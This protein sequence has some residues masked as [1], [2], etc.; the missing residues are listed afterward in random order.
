MTRRK[1]LDPPECLEAA[2]PVEALGVGIECIEIQAR[3]IPVARERFGRVDQTP[4]EAVIAPWFGDPQIADIEPAP[5]GRPVDAADE[6]A[7]RIMREDR[8][9]LFVA[10]AEALRDMIGKA[11]GHKGGVPGGRH[12][13]RRD[14]EGMRP[15]RFVHWLF[16][17]IVSACVV[18]SASGDPAMAETRS[19]PAATKA[20]SPPLAHVDEYRSVF[21]SCRDA[22]GAARLATRSMTV[23]GAPSL[24]LVDA[25]SLATSIEPAAAWTCEDTSDAVQAQTRFGRAL[26]MPI[27]PSRA[28]SGVLRDSGLVHGASDGSFVTGDLCPTAKPLARGFLQTLART[29]AHVPVALS[30]SGLWLVHHREDFRWLQEA[31][32]DGALDITWVNHS[33]TH[34]FDPKRPMAQDFL[35]RPGIDMDDEVLRTERLMIAHGGIPSVF[36]R[37]PGLVADKALMEKVRAFHLVALGADSWLVMS[38]TVP[39]PGAIILIHPNG[40]EPAGLKLFA[41]YLDAGKLPKPFRPI[42]EAPAR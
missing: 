42:I 24:L 40:N 27:P 41:R 21:Q 3:A 15:G 20:A 10:G 36:F 4:P 26:S 6:S 39:H 18:L 22:A 8:K 9:R 5:V 16:A 30:I 34:P 33:Y 28:P 12:V 7:I 32:R 23:D 37:F 1:I 19:S 13:M 14:A 2:A 17:V 29:G 11:V 38:P 35:L 25:T 31:M